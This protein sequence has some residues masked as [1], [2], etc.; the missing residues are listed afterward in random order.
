MPI[1]LGIIMDP[2]HL[3]RGQ[4]ETSLAILNAAQERNWQLYYMEQHDIYIENTAPKARTKLLQVSK[5]HKNW[6]EFTGDKTINLSDLDVLLMRKDPPFDTEYLTTTYLLDLVK[7]AGTLVINDP[8]GIRTA[9]E[10]LV[11]LQFP[12]LC[13]PHLVSSKAELLRDFI[14]EHKDTILKPLNAMAGNNVFRIRHDDPNINVT[15]ENLTDKGKKM[16]IA[17]RYI[18]EIKHGDKRIIMINGE[19][20]PYALARFAAPGETRANIMAG[21]SFKIQPLS[22]RDQEICSQ[23]GPT[24][25]NNGLWLVGV[26]IIGDYLTEINVTSPGCIPE[27]ESLTDISIT[28]KLLDLIQNSLKKHSTN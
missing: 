25:K 9:N 4:E 12:E 28:T 7:A 3:T 23:I 10:K 11:T 2:M 15:I 13:P 6:F 26:D 1:K 22:K 14:A 20:I 19:A 27:I 8:Q 16:I 21:G 17:Q 18:P 5:D 24:L